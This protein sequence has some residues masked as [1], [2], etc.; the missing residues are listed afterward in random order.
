MSALSRI[1][2]VFVIAAGAVAAAILIFAVNSD[3]LRSP[4]ID[5]SVVRDLQITVAVD[6]EVTNPGVYT[7]VASARLNDLIIAAGGFGPEANVSG[8]N[9]AARIG[10]GE[11]IHIPSL[12]SATPVSG[13]SAE[14]SLI[15]INTATVDELDELPGIGEVLASR[16][17][18]YRELFG[19]FSSVDQLIEVE[20]ISQST[21]D[22][23]RPLVTTGG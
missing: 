5:I 7:L 10:D 2:Y 20:G 8:L 19:A 13:N 21:I 4:D 9:L 18:E 11:T 14:S 1:I 22:E 12:V 16:I 23:L 17:V 3:R 15:N 6:G